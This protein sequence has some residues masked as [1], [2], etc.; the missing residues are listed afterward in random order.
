MRLTLKEM[1]EKG[2]G[3]Q[4]KVPTDKGESNTPPTENPIESELQEIM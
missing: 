2:R 4:W 1:Y 3:L